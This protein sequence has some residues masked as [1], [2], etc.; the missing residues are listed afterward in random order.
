MCILWDITLLGNRPDGI[1]VIT[2]PQLAAESRF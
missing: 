2:N 1:P